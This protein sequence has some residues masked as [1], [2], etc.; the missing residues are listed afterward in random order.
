MHAVFLTEKYPPVVGGG[1]THIRDLAEGLVAAGHRVTLLTETPGWVDRSTA[2]GDPRVDIRE[3]PGLVRACGSMDL[4]V[5]LQ[6]THAAL[7]SV[8]DA[9]VLHVFNRVPALLCGMLRG[10]LPRAVCLSS[11]ETV[12]PGQRLFGLWPEYDLEVAF[13]AAVRTL[14]VPDAVICGSRRYVEWALAEGYRPDTIHLAYHGTDVSVFRPDPSRRAAFRERMGWTGDFIVLVPARPVPR[15]RIED[16]IDALPAVRRTTPTARLVL[17]SPTA[18]GDDGYADQLRQ[19]IRD[20]ALDDHVSWLPGLGIEEMDDLM[21]AA[22]V[23]VLP[24]SDDGFGIVLLEAMAS[25][26]PVVTS[27]VPGH[28]E[29]V[30]RDTGALYPLGDTAA[31]AAEVV[32]VGLDDRERVV[33]AARQRVLQTFAKDRMVAEHLRTYA[34]VAAVTGDRVEAA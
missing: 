5:A 23:A 13:A 6:S 7:R 20:L 2:R 30:T 27:D 3:V 29:V 16:A 19:R 32:R 11:F 22:D 31:L 15:K 21:R 8:D 34:S 14:L 25:G 12:I 26:T 4:K 17:T 10:H 33:A 28:N 9:D 18:R 24:A 1:E